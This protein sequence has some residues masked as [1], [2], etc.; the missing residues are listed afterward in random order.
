MPTLR[1]GVA[2][3]RRISVEDGEM[4]HGRKSRSLL[5]DGYKRHILRDLESELIPVVGVTAANAPEASVTD[6]IAEDL[7]TQGLRVREWHIDRAYLSS[8]VVRERGEGVEIYCK[9]WPV[10]SGPYFPKTAFHLDW[11]RHEIRCPAEVTLPFEAGG[12]VQF[13][14]ATCGA[15]ELRERCTRSVQG[16]S[17]TIH[18]DERL[19]EEL[20]ER[21]L[22]PEGRAKLRERTAVEHGLAHVGQWQGDRARYVG[23]RK[24]LFDL[25]RTAVVNNLH[26]IARKPVVTAQAA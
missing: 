1:E 24:N 13:P 19:L 21:Q 23:V 18:P 20:R 12:V 8:R 16:R 25:R 14:A 26:V 9:A 17:V 2:P 4:R 7:K 11:E 6:S 10:R 15:C 3:E 5:V 22:T